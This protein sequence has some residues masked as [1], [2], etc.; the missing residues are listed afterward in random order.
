V[1]RRAHRRLRNKHTL[2]GARHILLAQQRVECDE[3]VEI[4]AVE[5]HARES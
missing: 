2:G 4:E 1:K 3:Q 5:L